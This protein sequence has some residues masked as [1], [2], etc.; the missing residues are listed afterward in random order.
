M[1]KQEVIGTTVTT[2]TRNQ[3]CWSRGNGMTRKIDV[4]LAHHRKL[5]SGK[6]R[7]AQLKSLHDNDIADKARNDGKEY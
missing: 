5:C 3:V 7:V 6:D 2:Q 4:S 1:M